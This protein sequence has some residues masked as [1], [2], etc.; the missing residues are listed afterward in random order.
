MAQQQAADE[1]RKAHAQARQSQDFG[2]GQA[3]AA[4]QLGAAKDMALRRS[5]RT[6]QQ[7]GERLRQLR[8]SAQLQL[9]A[10]SILHTE[11]SRLRQDATELQTEVKGMLQ[12]FANRLLSH[13]HFHKGAGSKANVVQAIDSLAKLLQSEKEQRVLENL[14]S[15]HQH[16]CLSSKLGLLQ[17]GQARD[18][19]QYLAQLQAWERSSETSV[20]PLARQ[21][22][23]LSARHSQI[24]EDQA[25]MR[26]KHDQLAAQLKGTE[27][28][29]A[30]LRA[31]AAELRGGAQR[32]AAALAGAKL[33]GQHLQ[34][35][36]AQL[37]EALQA[38]SKAQLAAQ[39]QD[40]ERHAAHLAA[41]RLAELEA[42]KRRAE[43]WELKLRQD[44][45]ALQS[46][47]EQLREAVGGCEAMAG[48]IFSLRK[49][50]E[51][52]Q[53]QRRGSEDALADARREGAT[54]QMRMQVAC[55]RLSAANAD[56]E[57]EIRRLEEDLVA[58][59]RA[60]T[61]LE[62]RAAARLSS[63]ENELQA[64]REELANLQRRWQQVSG[65]QSRAKL[66]V[67]SDKKMSAD[68]EG[69]LSEQLERRRAEQRAK[70]SALSQ[71][72]VRE[73][74]AA[75]KARQEMQKVKDAGAE[76]VIRTQEEQRRKLQGVQ[77]FKV[78]AEETR[79]AD[80]KSTSDEVAT[81]Q[82]RLQGLERDTAAMRQRL[83]ENEQRLSL[84]RQTDSEDS[85]A[86]SQAK[87]EIT[88]IEGSLQKAHEEDAALTRQVE[89]AKRMKEQAEV[90][91]PAVAP[92]REEPSFERSQWR[93]CFADDGQNLASFTALH[94]KLEGHI[95]RLQRHT[96]ELQ[97]VL[98]T[99][100]REVP[101]KEPL[102]FEAIARR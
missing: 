2:A 69:S 89:D 54:E 75:E 36:I 97:T 7:L 57:A 95:Q 18:A 63:A 22:E 30:R 64:A 94:D 10:A 26:A 87:A 24:Q 20:A 37:H 66:E 60:S 70:E 59:R 65:A 47:E 74:Q 19:S 58:R 46:L 42:A 35:Q 13:G 85:R 78:Q 43:D 79:R 6:R 33:S 21:Y 41:L 5:Q 71:Q 4:R 82:R 96:E 90:F 93:S 25:A 32:S 73:E 72:L 56:L 88:A 39:Q 28:A 31:E 12:M 40:A 29:A 17:A 101:R 86:M 83:E 102:A 48:E 62:V 1:R 3:E 11:Q 68:L 51:E 27:A 91:V 15:S 53:E 77:K 92:T 76:Q 84:L 50:Q 9:Q 44:E 38:S 100:A 99:Q 45:K 16:G 55:D 98:S 8:G 49:Q 14:T 61:D 81:Q 52:L 67:A 23:D 34:Q 80:L